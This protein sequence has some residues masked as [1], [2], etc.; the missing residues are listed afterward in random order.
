L[1]PGDLD[2]DQRVSDD[3]MTSAEISQQQGKLDS[4]D[5]EAIKN[6][7]ENYPRE[8][9]DSK[10]RKVTIYKPPERVVCTISHHLET[11]RTLKVPTETIVGAP[12][13]IDIYTIY[14]EFRDLPTV[15]HFYEPN[16][17][18][19]IEL[20]PDLVLV[21]PG[22]GSGTFGA[23]L[24]PLLDQLSQADITVA[25]F[26]CSRPE[27]YAEEVETL[28]V[29]FDREDEARA[30]IEFYQ[31]IIDTIT[32]RTEDLPEA[33]RPVV[34]SE[35]RPYRA[36]ELD[37]PIIEMAGGK[38][39]FAGVDNI[40]E[41]D[42]EMVVNTDPDFIIRIVGEEDYDGRDAHDISRMEQVRSEITARDELQN[43]RAVKNGQVY[44][45]A[46]PLWTY[47]PFSGCRHFIGLA[48]LAKWFHPD[49]FPELDP[50]ALH[51]RYMTEFQ[52]LDV[53][54]SEQGVYVYPSA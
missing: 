44:I 51:Q 16:V 29:L 37:V 13:N 52:G 35:N 8:I 9:V 47:M 5:L 38:S 21:H 25:C 43:V 42:P 48:Y 45:I 2:G 31:G 22:T 33:E 20:D 54:L 30:F 41:I 40:E 46:S 10:G 17:E 1:V 26:A 50:Q 24:T 14:P 11:L 19:M 32:E 12:E 28:G 3:E 18:K 36:S 6:I 27:I 15:G 53:D 23:Y 49:L 4:Q 39:I 34:Y 7:H